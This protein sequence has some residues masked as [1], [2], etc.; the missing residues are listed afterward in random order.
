MGAEWEVEE[1]DEEE[2]EGG[3]EEE[4]EE[5][6]RC[7]LLPELMCE[8]LPKIPIPWPLD[9]IPP[10]PMD[11]E[12]EEEE[13]EEPDEE[14]EEDP[15]WWLFPDPPLPLPLLLPVEPSIAKSCIIMLPEEEWCAGLSTDED[16]TERLVLPEMPPSPRNRLE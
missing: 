2:E 15:M 7:V 8:E 6:P 11:E 10:A 5:P 12:E 1:G 14:M 4:I 3:E 13:E 9:P 16:P